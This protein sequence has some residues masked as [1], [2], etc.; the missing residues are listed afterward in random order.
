MGLLD[1]PRTADVVAVGRVLC[2]VLSRRVYLAAAQLHA[3]ASSA[4]DNDAEEMLATTLIEEWNL[5]LNARNLHLSNPQVAHYLV[6]FIKKFKAAYNQ[7]FVG[8]T[9]YLDLLR[10]V[11]QE[12]ALGDEF[13]FLAARIAWDSPSSSLSIIRSE[14]RRVLSLAPERRTA[15]ETSFVA[16]MIESTAFLTK[17]DVP[18]HV[19]RA[20]LAR[21]LARVCEF[22]HVVK[23]Q[24]LFRQGKIESRAFL[25]LRGRIN[26]VN[27]DVTASA[28]TTTTS[29]SGAVKHY[30]VIATLAAGDSFGELSLVTRLQRSAT[31]MAACEAD[32]LVLDRDR[33]H[34]LQQALPGVSVQHLMVERAEFLARLSF[35]KGSDFGQCI[36]VAHDLH[37]VAYEPRHVFLQEPAH[38]RT[39]YIVKSGEIAVFVRR[40]VGTPPRQG[41]VRV[42]S[43][44]AQEF[45]GVAIATVNVGAQPAGAAASAASSTATTPTVLAPGTTWDLRTT[46][47][48]CTT[49]VVMLELSE[50][51]WRRLNPTCLQII[52]S[53]LLERHDWHDELATRQ[54]EP[55]YF[56]AERPWLQLPLVPGA[57]FS[58]AC[59]CGG[60]CHSSDAARAGGNGAPI[61]LLNRPTSNLA[62]HVQSRKTHASPFAK[63]FPSESPRTAAEA[64]D[65]PPTAAAVAVDD[66]SK[67]ITSRQPQW[68][69]TTKT[70]MPSPLGGSFASHGGALPPTT[71]RFDVKGPKT[72]MTIASQSPERLRA[73]QEAQ[74]QAEAERQR[75]AAAA[76]EM[77]TRAQEITAMWRPSVS[78]QQRQR[79]TSLF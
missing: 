44:G 18:A 54:K 61:A 46:V 35:F 17:F 22:W 4:L 8:R 41:L 52:R 43:I 66:Q 10:R 36:R 63:F 40:Q 26:I 34:L 56:H 51:G 48:M 47:Y 72:L 58:C 49:R 11:H 71:P 45:F 77:E 55:T 12:P 1:K 25:I 67:S 7:K 76:K 68:E 31:A 3:T 19:D 59:G 9:M 16:R 28:A 27:E 20:K 2:L 29:T 60:R 30:E 78:Q 23:D 50:R 32:L 33:L 79:R 38:Q 37:E 65:A 13:E 39:L 53:V 64:S 70:A 62:R 73:K 14:T 75:L 15:A 69:P 57:G 42:A 21:H 24:P 6:T 5:V 74:A